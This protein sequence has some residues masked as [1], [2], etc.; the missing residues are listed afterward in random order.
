M[1]MI[2]L[3]WWLT[4][5]YL[6]VLVVALAWA[7]MS[8]AFY[9]WR[10]SVSLRKVADGLAAV[11]DH[12]APLSA[13]LVAANAGLTAIAG[14]LSSA[15]DHLVATDRGLGVVTGGDEKPQSEVA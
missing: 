11:R 15:R 13:H 4:G 12:T 14:S 2:T 3:L 7:T 9:A 6:A 8:V 5:I 10:I 1:D